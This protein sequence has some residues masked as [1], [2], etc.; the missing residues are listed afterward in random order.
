MH[1]HDG[2]RHQAH[3]GALGLD[4][5][6]SMQLPDAWS[7]PASRAH[8]LWPAQQADRGPSSNCSSTAD[9]RVPGAMRASGCMQVSLRERQLT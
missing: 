3:K 9:N 8:S 1:R 2:R 6:V 4:R 5:A 7:C